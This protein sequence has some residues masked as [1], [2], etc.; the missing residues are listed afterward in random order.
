MPIQL[1]TPPST[2]ASSSNTI[3]L[4]YTCTHVRIFRI[5]E[6]DGA[7]AAAYDAKAPALPSLLTT[8]A[9]GET[10]VLAP[11]GQGDVF[12]GALSLALMS[13]G[14]R[15][16]RCPDCESEEGDGERWEEVRKEEEE[17]GWEKLDVGSGEVLFDIDGDGDVDVDEGKLSSS[18]LEREGKGMGWWDLGLLEDLQI[19]DQDTEMGGADDDEDGDGDIVVHEKAVSPFEVV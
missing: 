3:T 14:E 5:E 17:D 16:R 9:H 4:T 7:T 10:L 19:E 15:E 2:T 1:P 6:V 13:A 12:L 18:L 8:N 11:P